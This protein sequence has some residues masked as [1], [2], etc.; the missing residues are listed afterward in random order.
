M[1]FIIT[2]AVRRDAAHRLNRRAERSP[3]RQKLEPLVHREIQY[4]EIK[5]HVNLR[6]S[7]FRLR[8]GNLAGVEVAW[9]KTEVFGKDALV[10]ATRDPTGAEKISV[11]LAGNPLETPATGRP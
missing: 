5:G 10:A 6:I 2:V 7:E 9:G 11:K 3:A 8:R 4:I 1:T